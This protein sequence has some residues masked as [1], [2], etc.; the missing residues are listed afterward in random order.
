MIQ[1]NKKSYKN[2][3]QILINLYRV[4][5]KMGKQTIE[6]VQNKLDKMDVVSD[7][8]WLLEKIEEIRKTL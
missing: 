1:N 6:S 4:R 7:K 5:H 2:F 8:K 3:T